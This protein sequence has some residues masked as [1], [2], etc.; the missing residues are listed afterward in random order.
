MALLVILEVNRRTYIG[1]RATQVVPSMSSIVG[2][3]RYSVHCHS[4]TIEWVLSTLSLRPL[5]RE[6]LPTLSWEGLEPAALESVA[7]ESSTLVIQFYSDLGLELECV[8]NMGQRSPTLRFLDDSPLRIRNIERNSLCAFKH[9]IRL[10]QSW[11]RPDGVDGL[12]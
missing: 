2:L 10:L 7:V 11:D 3:S 6:T 9:S 8:A 12:V 5:S 4:L 1:T